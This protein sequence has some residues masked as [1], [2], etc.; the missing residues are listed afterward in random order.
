[1]NAMDLNTEL[2][3]LN[4][5]RSA[6]EQGL[7]F[8]TLLERLNRSL[9]AALIAKSTSSALPQEALAYFDRLDPLSRSLPKTLLTK[10][11]SS[12]ANEV[13]R[14][15]GHILYITRMVKGV[16]ATAD[17][18]SDVD[19]VD[20]FLSVFAD[21]SAKLVGMRVALYKQGEGS[22]PLKLAIPTDL[23]S[24]RLSAVSSLE[25]HCRSKVRNEIKTLRHDTRQ[26][27][28]RD[29]LPAAMREELQQIQDDL[30]ATLQH[31]DRGGDISEIPVLFETLQWDPAP[32]STQDLADVLKGEEVEEIPVEEIT[33]TAPETP[34]DRAEPG[35][36]DTLHYWLNT[37]LDVSWDTVRRWQKRRISP[38]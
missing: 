26:L 37:P 32:M 22:E 11:I 38:D 21:H 24:K 3:V 2:D 35:F 16:E 27:L 20:L 34:Q 10:R 12:L 5:K 6:L 7:H 1:M 4:T 9:D 18:G 30:Q 8:G 17:G 19:D 36:R 29:E 15:F 13:E 14:D 25:K 33:I 23:L 28:K 31:I